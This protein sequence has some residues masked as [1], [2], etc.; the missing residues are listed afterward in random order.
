MMGFKKNNSGEEHDAIA[1][2]IA[3]RSA[4]ATLAQLSTVAEGMNAA[5]LRGYLRAHAWPLVW[6]EVQ[7]VAAGG[8][9]TKTQVNELAG[10]ALEQT[11]HAVTRAYLAA[12]IVAMPT[13]H[14]G[15]RAAA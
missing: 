4:S 10:R 14:I 12:P 6:A 7:D 3:D 9:L 15:R 11:V 2:E 8:R 13:P 1:H 5:Q